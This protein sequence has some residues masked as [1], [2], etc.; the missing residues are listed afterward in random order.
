MTTS[1][2]FEAKKPDTGREAGVLSQRVELGSL[3]TLDDRTVGVFEF[4]DVTP[5]YVVRS[6][7]ESNWITAAP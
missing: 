7:L 3:N 1:S 6:G 2:E 5:N 4:L